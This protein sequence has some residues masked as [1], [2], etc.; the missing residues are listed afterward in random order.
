MNSDTVDSAA[1][2]L[3]CGLPHTAYVLLWYPLFTQ[4]FIFREVENLRKEVPLQ[5]YTLYGANLRNCSR[6]MLEA[7]TKPVR[8]GLKSFGRI[9][10]ALLWEGLRKPRKLG[11][12][13]RKSMAHRWQS[14]ETFG[15]NLWA[16]GVGVCL[17]KQF[18]EEGIDLV[19]APWP[20]GA[21]T[22]ARVG[23][24]LAGL[25]FAISVRGDNLDPAD[26]DLEGKLEDALFIRANNAA[27]RERIRSFGKGVARE[28]TELVYNS[29]TLRQNEALSPKKDKAQVFRILALGRFDVTKGFDVLLRACEL[30]KKRGISFHLTLAGGGGRLMGLGSLENKLRDL[31]KT[32][33]LEREVSMPGLVNHNDLPKIMASHDVFAAPCV[34]HESGR[35][36]GIPNTV[37]EAMSCGLPIVATDVNALPE[38]VINGETGLSVPPNDPAALADALVRIKDNPEEAAR[39]GRNAANLA[40]EMFDPEANARK[41]G[42]LL[43]SWRGK[44]C[45]E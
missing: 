14:L 18:R 23:A 37:I 33:D 34:V 8:F 10:G 36:D 22:A 43:V 19:Y 15:E 5:V 24:E 20:R 2:P 26:P 31:R 27:D 21:A 41:L 32:L 39:L 28:K 9:F 11:K 3:P 42:N 30:L 45:V 1:M 40:R 35:R 29:L 6:E 25:P 7:S 16:F 13:F 17:G 44:R 4:P 12:L 38:V